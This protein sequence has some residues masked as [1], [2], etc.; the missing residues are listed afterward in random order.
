MT[1]EFSFGLAEIP[2]CVTTGRY[3]RKRIILRFRQFRES[4]HRERFPVRLNLLW[5][6]SSPDQ[7]GLASASE[8]ARLERFEND[9]LDVVETNVIAVLAAVLTC[10]G[11]REFVFHTNNAEQC[12]EALAQIPQ[13]AEPF[14]LTIHAHDDRDWSYLSAV[15]RDFE[16]NECDSE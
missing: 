12:L 9:L 13:D 2:W 7:N 6:M 1:T 3:K 10:D 4:F 14:P 16:P 11:T 15:I 5:R 8:T